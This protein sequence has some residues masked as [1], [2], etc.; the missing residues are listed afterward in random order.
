MTEEAGSGQSAA[1][2][3]TLVNDYIRFWTHVAGNTGRA[4]SGSYTV[5]EAV[6]DFQA[7]LSTS[8]TLALKL[9]EKCWGLGEALAA[10][11]GIW[12]EEVKLFREVT[13]RPLTLRAAPLRAIGFGPEHPL[14][15]SVVTFDPPVVTGRNDRFRVTVRFPPGP[16]G[17][18][19]VYEGDI[20]A[21]EV[22]G[23]VTDP[24]RP[25]NRDGGPLQ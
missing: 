3:A 16:P 11:P 2:L 14:P 12:T 9:A 4:L 21:Q 22:N 1:L 15:P 19:F 20:L 17:Q 5:P 18:T 10:S 23:P 25:N 7:C 13:H 8:T 24:I 6:S